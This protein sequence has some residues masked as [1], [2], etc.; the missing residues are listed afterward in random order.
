MSGR[1]FL[2]ALVLLA[3]GL[4]LTGIARSLLPCPGR[5]EIPSDC[6]GFPEQTLD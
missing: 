6:S 3:A 2:L 1:R 4:H 5:P